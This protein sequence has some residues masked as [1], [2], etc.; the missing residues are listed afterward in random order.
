MIAMSLVG[1]IWQASRVPAVAP[2]LASALASSPAGAGSRSSPLV[3]ST[4]Q[5]VQRARPPHTE[6]CGMRFSRSVSSTVAPASMAKVRP[7]GRSASAAGGG[8]SASSHTARGERHSHQREMKA[9]ADPR[10]QPICASVLSVR[11]ASSSDDW[12]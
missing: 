2:I 10:D 11:L 4:R 7:P 1:V 3:T 8:G 12:T 9:E 6:A 5:V